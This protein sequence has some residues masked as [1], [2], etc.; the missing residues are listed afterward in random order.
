MGCRIAVLG[1]PGAGKG[2]QAVRIAQRFEVP[3]ISTGEIFRAHLRDGTAIG[4]EVQPYLDA[5]RLVPD[6]LTCAIVSERLQA[7]DCRRGYALDGFPRSLPQATALMRLGA[8]GEGLD[9]AID[10]DVPDEELVDRLTA[11]RFCPKCGKVFN[12]KFSP[13]ANGDA[14]D[15]PGCGGLLER[16]SDDEED[17][18]RERLRVYHETTKPMMEYLESLGILRTVPAAH[19]SPDDVFKKVEELLEA[20]GAA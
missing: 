4:R 10:I 14:C 3:H 17:T 6:E 18:I 13:S 7:D 20:A 19:A 16:R 15:A 12:V 8:C 9:T 2:T 1:A 5:G 11:R